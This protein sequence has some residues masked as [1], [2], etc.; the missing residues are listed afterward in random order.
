MG[1]NLNYKTLITILKYDPLKYYK[2]G[3]G[4]TGY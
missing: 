4:Q 3:T 1:R 2:S